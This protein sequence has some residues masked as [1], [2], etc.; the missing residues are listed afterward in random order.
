[1]SDSVRLGFERELW[2]ALDLLRGRMSIPAQRRL[3]LGLV[4]LAGL[5]EAP[6]GREL[7]ADARWEQLRQRP[8]AELGVALDHALGLLRDH[9]P[10]TLDALPAT[11]GGQTLPPDRLEALVAAVHALR[12]ELSRGHRRDLLGRC[13]EFLLERF[14]EGASRGEFYTP[15]SVGRLM[16]RLVGPLGPTVYDPCCGSGGLLARAAQAAGTDAVRVVGQECNP[17]T[18][19]IAAMALYSQ[20]LDAALGPRA[21]DTLELDLH[22]NIEAQTVLANPPFNLRQWCT[23]AVADDP[24]WRWGKPPAANAN[25]A[26][27]QH[28]LAH[29]GPGGRGAVVLANGALTTRVRPERAIRSALLDAGAVEAV[30]GLPDQLFYATAIPASVWL[31]RPPVEGAP[32]PVLFVRADDLGEMDGRS[33]Q[34]LPGAAIERIGGWVDAF[35]R[36]ERPAEPGLVGVADRERLRTRRDELSPG[37]WVGLELPPQPQSADRADLEAAWQAASASLLQATAAVDAALAALDGP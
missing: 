10:E 14:A 30:V 28:I 23:G 27:V 9:E 31:L 33:H 32:P 5:P 17:E 1:M 12:E 11:L 19:A 34:V 7:P 18:R 26:W 20:G 6:G 2:A 15:P 24:R 22:D 29:L 3:V 37:L 4:F 35:R 8:A 25:Y 13:Y 36:G 21:A 16:V